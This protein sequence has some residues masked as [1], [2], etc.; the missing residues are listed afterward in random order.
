MDGHS[1]TAMDIPA[2]ANKNKLISEYVI[3]VEQEHVQ[4]GGGLDEALHELICPPRFLFRDEVK[5]LLAY[6]TKEKGQAG[7]E[8]AFAEYAVEWGST[9][10]QT[11]I[12]KT[13][14]DIG[15]DYLFLIGAQ[16]SI[17]LHAS[18]AKWVL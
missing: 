10:S 18:Y 1:F 13:A 7:F 6:Y 2:L 8:A 16:S 15:T 11:T 4:L 14:V 3:S 12:M 5:R 17:Y 9:P